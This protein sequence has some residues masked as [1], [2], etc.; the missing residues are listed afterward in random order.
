MINTFTINLNRA[1]LY[2]L[3]YM[4]MTFYWQVTVWFFYL[5]PRVLSK[6]FEM[7]NPGDISFMISIQIQRNRTREILGLSQMAYLDKL[8]LDVARRNSSEIS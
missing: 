1:E 3:C 4:W 2:F 6:N 8:L 5:R 7:K